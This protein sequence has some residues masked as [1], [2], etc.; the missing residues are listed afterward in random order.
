MTTP[1]RTRSASGTALAMVLGS[2][3]SLQVGA[4][5]ASH[6]IPE[7]GA[8]G[9]ALLRLGIAA[10]VLLAVVRPAAHR[11]DAAQWRDVVLF[12]L[13]LGG[14]NAMF[15]AA[16]DRIPLGAAVTIEF[17]GPLVLSAALSRH[18][19]DLLWVA[20]AAGGVVMIGAAQHDVGASLDP[21]GV[22]FALGAAALWAGYILTSSRT[23]RSVP[24]QGG[25][26]MATAVGALLLLPVGARGAAQ[27]TASPG[28]IALAIGTALLASVVPVALEFAALRRLPPRPF[29]IALSLEPAVATLFGWMLLHEHV[30]WAHV[31][32]VTIVVAASVGSAVTSHRH[33]VSPGDAS[34]TPSSDLDSTDTTSG[35]LEAAPSDVRPAAPSGTLVTGADADADA[36][37]DERVLEPSAA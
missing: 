4:V 31:V 36:E 25:L 22:G 18:V 24:G 23:G 12:G 2:C 37:R 30:S 6:L 3:V 7:L 1:A 29:G 8:P 15:Y 10:V 27:L 19:R 35:A 11:W 9:T 14:M 33:D 34:A 28:M 13:T 26:A 16:I 32:A 21:A 17:L 20:L 5:G